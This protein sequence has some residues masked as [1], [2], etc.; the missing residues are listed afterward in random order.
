MLARKCQT[1]QSS[2]TPQNPSASKSNW[3]S[4]CSIDGTGSSNH[5][6]VFA[7]LL[8]CSRN[9]DPS[10]EPIYHTKRYTLAEGIPINDDPSLLTVWQCISQAPGLSVMKAI[11]G[12]P[13]P[14][15]VATSR[16]GAIVLE[17]VCLET[18]NFRA[19]PLT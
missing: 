7:K 13:P 18:Q 3:D 4:T 10:P 17:L 15:E 1:S 19:F 5:P 2:F 12:Y 14:G 9:C 16:R 11:T 8:F 6:S